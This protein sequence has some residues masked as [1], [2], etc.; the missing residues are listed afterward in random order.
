MKF[1]VIGGCTIVQDQG[2]FL[3]FLSVVGEGTSGRW[4]CALLLSNS[5]SAARHAADV[6]GSVLAIDPKGRIYCTHSTAL[7][8]RIFDLVTTISV[9]DLELR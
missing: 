1:S 4:T 6:S 8:V 2:G 3:A 9:I 7:P 5:V